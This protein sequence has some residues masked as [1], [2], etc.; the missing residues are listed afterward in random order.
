LLGDSYSNIFSLSGM[1]W[2]NGAGFA[3]R[4]SYRLKRPLD[5]IVI[6]DGGSYT[7]REELLRE[8]ARGKDRLKGKRLVIWEFAMRDLADGDWKRLDLPQAH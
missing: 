1:G 3:E 2:G 5:K 7:T 6:N 4:L 8:Y